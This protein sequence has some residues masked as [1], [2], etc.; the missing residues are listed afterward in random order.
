MLLNGYEAIYQPLHPRSYNN[1]MVY[2]H[3]LK[4]EEKLG[5]LLNSEEVVHHIDHNRLNN[6]LDNLLIFHSQQDHISFHSNEDMTRLQ[7]LE[8]GSYI[9][10]DRQANPYKC[11]Y[12]NKFKNHNA[13]SCWECYIKYHPNS[14]SLIKNISR[15]E[16]KEL[17][18]KYSFVDIGKRYGIT[19]NAVRKW[20]DKFHLPRTKKEIKNYSDE[21][22]RQI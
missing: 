11:P 19:D 3:I 1:G 9:C 4:A 7:L 8:D 18:R 21:E 20:C 6:S 15:N 2:I 17:I 5:R 10:V 13:N 14:N 12:C 16:L 22:W